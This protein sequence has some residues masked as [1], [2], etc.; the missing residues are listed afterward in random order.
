MF[1]NHPINVIFNTKIRLSPIL[2]HG[3][4]YNYYLVYNICI[5]NEK[6]LEACMQYFIISIRGYQTG[7]I[8]QSTDLHI[9]YIHISLVDY[10]YDGRR[11]IHWNTVVIF[12]AVTFNDWWNVPRH[13][14]IDCLSCKII[15]FMFKCECVWK[16]CPAAS[17]TCSASEF[18]RSRALFHHTIENWSAVC[19]RNRRT[20]RRF[21]SNRFAARPRC[22]A[23]TIR[24][25]EYDLNIE[26]LGH[27]Q[28]RTD[29]SVII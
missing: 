7:L 15:K 16:F 10:R 1:P 20:S 25:D 28:H 12:I 13:S 5:K 6:L 21:G 27:V 9:L 23:Q 29:Q 17:S 24:W 26:Q 4:H 3:L 8:M 14:S 11:K 19:W 22:V 2:A 18:W